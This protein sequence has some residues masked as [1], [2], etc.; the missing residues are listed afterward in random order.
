M[1]RVVASFVFG[2]TVVDIVQNMHSAK[3]VKREGFIINEVAKFS[4]IFSAV[5]DRIGTNR[6][7]FI[8]VPR[9]RLCSVFVCITE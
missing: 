7:I 5:R 2:G 8:Y 4:Y 9:I 6:L 3:A 1:P